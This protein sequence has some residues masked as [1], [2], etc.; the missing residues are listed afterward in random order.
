MIIVVLFYYYYYLTAYMCSIFVFQKSHFLFSPGISS[1]PY[2]P[3]SPAPFLFSPFS[4]SEN[5]SDRDDQIKRGRPPANAIQT[6]ISQGSVAESS[7]R[8]QYCSRVFPR[9]K[10]LQAHM[11]THTGYYYLLTITGGLVALAMNRK[12][13]SDLQCLDIL[14]KRFGWWAFLL[15]AAVS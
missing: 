7:I 13:E 4:L 15:Y 9:E 1:V 14:P 8:C 11:R 6:L 12:P 10:S 5:V 3:E 2:S